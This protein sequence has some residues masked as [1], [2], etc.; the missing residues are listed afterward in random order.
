MALLRL[1]ALLALAA[2]N[3]AGAQPTPTPTTA[4]SGVKVPAG[5]T[6]LPALAAQ[7][8]VPNAEAWGDP[9]RG[10]YAVW[11]HLQGSGATAEAVLAGLAAEQIATSDLVKPE[12]DGIVAATFAKGAYTGRLRARIADGAITTLACFANR[13]EP[14]S[15]E[16]PC[17][18]VLGALP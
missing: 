14:K 12:A 2:C 6:V 3:S 10:C 8:G 17:T 9:A 11:F 5:W 16:L 13:R 7:T 4:A 15:C 1:A 18:T